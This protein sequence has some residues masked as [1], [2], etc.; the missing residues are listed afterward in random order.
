[1]AS[2]ILFAILYVCAVVSTQLGYLITTF[3][4]S[5]TYW[6]YVIIYE[7]VLFVYAWVTMILNY[8]YLFIVV[9]PLFY[10]TTSICLTYAL[11]IGFLIVIGADSSV[12]IQDYT[13]LQNMIG[14]I[15]ALSASINASYSY[16]SSN[17]EKAA[18]VYFILRV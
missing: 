10:L 9:K 7:A 6:R 4:D 2:L 8:P 14:P 17:Q 5:T 1:M 18:P 3:Q 13:I 15:A 11:F 16:L 12:V